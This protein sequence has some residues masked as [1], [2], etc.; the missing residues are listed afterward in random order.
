MRPE[1]LRNRRPI[2]ESGVSCYKSNFVM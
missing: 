1:G 2:D